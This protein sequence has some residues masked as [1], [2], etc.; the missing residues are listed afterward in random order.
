M[1]RKKAPSKAFYFRVRSTGKLTSE[2]FKLLV[3]NYLETFE[4]KGLLC[5]FYNDWTPDQGMFWDTT[6][7]TLGNHISSPEQVLDGIIHFALRGLREMGFDIKANKLCE[8]IETKYIEVD[9][10]KK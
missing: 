5:E 4:C 10:D 3:R 6:S 1:N 9:I 7:W 8:F 2:Q